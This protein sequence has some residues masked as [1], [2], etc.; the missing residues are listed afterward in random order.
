[1]LDMMLF[2]SLE[3]TLSLV[4]GVCCTLNEVGGAVVFRGDFAAGF[5]DFIMYGFRSGI[6]LVFL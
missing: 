1:M 6:D 2:F 3:V 4:L 5:L